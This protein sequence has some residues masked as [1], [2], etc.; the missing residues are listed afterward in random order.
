MMWKW[1]ITDEKIKE[2]KTLLVNNGIRESAR[3]ASVSFYTAWCISKGRYDN[4]EAL[5]PKII[6]GNR[7]PITGFYAND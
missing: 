5:N 2:V 4:H 7:C 3:R 1:K 6:F